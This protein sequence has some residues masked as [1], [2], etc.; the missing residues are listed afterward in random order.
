M[1]RTANGG[2]PNRREM[3]KSKLQ[4]GKQELSAGERAGQQAE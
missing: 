4:A 1:S 2:K 3:S